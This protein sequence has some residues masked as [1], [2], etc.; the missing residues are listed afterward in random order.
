MS[1]YKQ[2]LI[3]QSYQPIM[4]AIQNKKIVVEMLHTKNNSTYYNRQTVLTAQRSLS[5]TI[6]HDVPSPVVYHSAAH[7]KRVLPL[8]ALHKKVT[9]IFQP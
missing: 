9:E 3:L 2:G 1:C 4:M 7:Y 5:C 6:M 8:F